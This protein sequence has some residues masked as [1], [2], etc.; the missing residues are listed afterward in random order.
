[1]ATMVIYKVAEMPPE[2]L[3]EYEQ[4]L[5]DT[6]PDDDTDYILDAYERERDGAERDGAEQADEQADEYDS[7]LYDSDLWEEA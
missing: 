7:D 6:A 3:S 1:M 4:W 5:R 2:G